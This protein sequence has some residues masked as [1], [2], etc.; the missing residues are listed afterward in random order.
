MPL[1]HPD[2]DAEMEKAGIQMVADL[3]A[4]YPPAFGDNLEPEVTVD[5]PPMCIGVRDDATTVNVTV[6]KDYP[7]GRKDA[8][9]QVKREME[10][11]GI[12]R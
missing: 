5:H 1:D 2:Y 6:A 4:D 3:I 8:C 11:A 7:P 10:E 12:S 9:L